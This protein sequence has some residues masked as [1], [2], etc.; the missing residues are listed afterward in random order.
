[1]HGPQSSSLCHTE[2][3]DVLFPL[4]LALCRATCFDKG[5]VHCTSKGTRPVSLHLKRVG[6][7][8]RLDIQKT[9]LVNRGT[10]PSS[11]RV[12]SIEDRLELK[13]CVVASSIFHETEVLT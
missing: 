7:D 2:K 10:K 1:M 13:R 12:S 4:L 5:I 3:E 11:D 6:A 9:F 8:R